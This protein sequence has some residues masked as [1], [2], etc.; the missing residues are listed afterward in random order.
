MCVLAV[1]AI[2]NEPTAK[3][4]ITELIIF[5]IVKNPHQRNL[6]LAYTLFYSH[7]FSDIVN[8]IRNALDGK[9]LALMNVLHLLERVDIKNV[10][11]FPPY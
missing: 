10:L 8:G 11:F 6:T 7:L 4:K 9:Y 5:I 2:S 3:L 1:R